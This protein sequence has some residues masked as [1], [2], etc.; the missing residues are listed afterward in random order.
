MR[1]GFHLSIGKGLPA[2]LTTA[3]RV[4]CEALQIFG[5]NPRQWRSHR[6]TAAEIETFA[7]QRPR[8]GIAP[9]VVHLS[10]L[11]NLAS[12]DAELYQRSRTVL[13]QEWRL[14]GQLGAEYLVVHP[15]HRLGLGPEP[16]HERIAAAVAGVLAELDPVT[17]Y[18]MLLLE[19]ASGQGSE[20]GARLAELRQIRTRIGSRAD[21]VGYCLDTAHA[22]AAGYPLHRRRGLKDFLASVRLELGLDQVRLLHLNDSK[23]PCGSRI[24]RHWHL[25]CGVIGADGFRRILQ[26]PD[27]QPIPAVMETPK[28]SLEDDL[29][30]LYRARRLQ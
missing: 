15:G 25:A 26:A 29:S 23:A 11:P 27:L 17:D 6:F 10:Y 28:K 22:L 1:L 13:E 19:N 5:R 4:G 12:P 7:R 21:R 9:L 18:P 14:A 16:A 24:D 3:R 30:N 20:V 2:L 8:S